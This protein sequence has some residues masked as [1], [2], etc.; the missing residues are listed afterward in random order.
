MK[1]LDTNGFTITELLIAIAISS[2]LAT[3]L[4]AVSMTYYGN[5][6]Q[7]NQTAEL[8]IEN[9][10]ALRAIIE[11][12]RLADSIQASGV[13]TDANA[14]GTGW[15]TDDGANVLVIGSPATTSDYDV[16]YDDSTGYPY[17]NELIY[18]VSGN[19]LNKRIIRNDAATGNRATT[20]CPA[21]VASSSCPA[22]RT[23]STHIT[24]L[25]FEF[26]DELGASTT[27]PAL[28][29]SVKVTITASRQS[30]GK[31]ISYTNS[32]QTTLRNR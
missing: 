14:P 16:I 7:N 27:D 11:D 18:Y 9:H 4:L 21:A 20:S 31:T 10:Y 8:G 17:S 32:M 26:F 25:S 24:D 28:A 23:Y 22:D 1:R 12:I 2:I 19:S 5:V 3:V 30:F 13:L 15:N 6:I 29:R